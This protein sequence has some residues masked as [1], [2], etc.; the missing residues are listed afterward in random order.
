MS[1]E[2]S[3]S[4]IDLSALMH[5]PIPMLGMDVFSKEVFAEDSPLTDY[6]AV[7]A[8]QSLESQIFDMPKA[9]LKLLKTGR[10]MDNLTSPGYWTS[11]LYDGTNPESL[12]GLLRPVKFFTESFEGKDNVVAGAPSP[13]N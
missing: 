3:F 12:S 10:M 6:L 1:L 13:Y 11:K 4:V 9:R 8:G 2:V 7:L 5:M